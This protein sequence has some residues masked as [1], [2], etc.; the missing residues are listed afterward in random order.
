MAVHLET[1]AQTAVRVRAALKA[2]FPGVTFSVRSKTYSGGA[3]IRV[4]WTDGPPCAAVH[5]VTD[6]MEG[7]DFDGMQDLKTY[8]SNGAGADFIFCTRKLSRE[9]EDIAEAKAWL[10]EHFT[11]SPTDYDAVRR[12][13]R[14]AFARDLLNRETWQQVANVTGYG[15]YERRA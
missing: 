12:P 9:A 3:S 5:R 10:A 6:P 15:G 4:E 11:S 7:A 13:F 8:R 1:C 2:A 14:M